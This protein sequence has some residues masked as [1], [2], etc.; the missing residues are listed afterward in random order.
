MGLDEE[1]INSP[2]YH[3]VKEQ[4][5]ATGQAATTASKVSF[6]LDLYSGT[7]GLNQDGIGYIV[8]RGQ[9]TPH[10]RSKAW[11]MNPI[12]PEAISV[13][14]DYWG[15]DEGAADLLHGLVRAIRPSVVLETGTHK[16]R[17]TSAMAS[18]LVKNGTGSL[19]TIDSIDYGLFEN[20]ALTEQ[21]KSIVTQVIGKTPEAFNS[22]EVKDLSGIEFAFVDGDHTLAGMLRDMKF[23][24]SRMAERCTVVVDNALDAGYPDLARYFSD[25]KTGV[26]IP[27]MS[28]MQVIELKKK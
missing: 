17:S 3:E 22:P 27:T 28:G 12:F 7:S 4:A 13:R 21:E 9:M 14:M 16:G 26:C 8:L 19:T 23:V 24:E 25:T 1:Y 10:G 20:G 5:S 15:I 11:E 6:S 18:A 2:E